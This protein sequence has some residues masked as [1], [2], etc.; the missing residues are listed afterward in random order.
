MKPGRVY[1]VA[2][3]AGHVPVVCNSNKRERD[4]ACA[5][6]MCARSGLTAGS[7]YRQQRMP[8][9][10]VTRMCM[11][12]HLKRRDTGPV[13]RLSSR[14]SG[15]AWRRYDSGRSLRQPWLQFPVR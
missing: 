15:M 7:Q 9:A 13:C 14:T 4:H 2:A 11:I 8:L 6:M 12:G 10:R 3:S 1:G 5:S